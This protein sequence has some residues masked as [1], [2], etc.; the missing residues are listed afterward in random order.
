MAGLCWMVVAVAF[1]LSIGNSVAEIP[2]WL[3]QTVQT[4]KNRYF[5]PNMQ[6]SLAANI[7]VDQNQLE[8]AFNADDPALVKTKLESDEVYEGTNVVVAKPKH[9]IGYDDHAE[10]IV[11]DKIGP[12]VAGSEGNRLIFYSYFSPCADKCA[13]KTHPYRILKKLKKVFDAYWEDSA[14]VFTRVYDMNG[15]IPEGNI[16]ESLTNLGRSV[17]QNNI[18][19][20]YTPYKSVFTCISCFIDGNLAE[21]CFKN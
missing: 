4:I 20:C 12:L 6:F 17:R 2:D 7:P 13:S 18:F 11:L 3:T 1:S 10:N 14:F 9:M 16:K 8:N 21:A 19:R 5:I 15:D